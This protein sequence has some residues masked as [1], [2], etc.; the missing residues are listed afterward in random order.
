MSDIFDTKI[1][2]ELTLKELEDITLALR[3]VN[4]AFSGNIRSELEEKLSDI[5]FITKMSSNE[6]QEQ[7]PCMKEP[8]YNCGIKCSRCGREL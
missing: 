1:Q 3:M 8:S 4:K 5:A 2:V 6:E 7:C